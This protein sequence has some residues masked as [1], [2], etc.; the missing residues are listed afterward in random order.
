MAGLESL[1]LKLR[2]IAPGA[3]IEFDLGVRTSTLVA[4]GVPDALERIARHIEANES[5]VEPSRA[6]RIVPVESVHATGLASIVERALGQEGA[7]ESTTLRVRAEPSV[8][9]ISLS[10]APALV[11]FAEEVIRT[12]DVATRGG[13]AEAVYL[14]PVRSGDTE[15]T[16]AELAA[17]VPGASVRSLPM[18]RAIVVRADEASKQGVLRALEDLGVDAAPAVAPLVCEMIDLTHVAP[19]VAAAVIEAVVCDRARWPEELRADAQRSVIQRPPCAQPFLDSASVVVVAPPRLADVATRLALLIDTVQPP[20][21][22][23]ELRAY[24][25][26][27]AAVGRALDAS[28]QALDARAKP[29]IA[30]PATLVDLSAGGLVVALGEPSWLD[31][32]D[33]AVRSVDVR[34]LRDAARVRTMSARHA[35]PRSLARLIEPLLASIDADDAPRATEP[36]VPRERAPT[37][38]A[39]DERGGTVTVIASPM[40]LDLAE[41]ILV[42]LDHESLETPRRSFRLYEL[43]GADAAVVAK[44]IVDRFEL[45]DPGEEPPL[46]RIQPAR[47][48][49]L[50]RASDAQR[51]VIRRLIESM[52]AKAE[53][54]VTVQERM[55]DVQQLAIEPAEVDRIFGAL[56]M[57]RANAAAAAR[58]SPG[59]AAPGATPSQRTAQEVRETAVPVAL[60]VDRDRGLI[61]CFATPAAVARNAESVRQLARLAPSDDATLRRIALPPSANPLE[62]AALA[63]VGCERLVVDD[64][65]LPIG[66][67]VVIAADPAAAGVLLFATERDAAIVRE[68]LA[69]LA[70]VQ[71]TET[72]VARRLVL[73]QAEVD[74]VAGALRFIAAR[75]GGLPRVAV[76]PDRGGVVVMG[77]AAEVAASSSLASRFDRSA[78]EARDELRVL[79]LRS[80]DAVEAASV[81]GLM[82]PANAP[83]PVIQVASPTSVVLHGEASVLDMISAPLMELDKPGGRLPSAVEVLPVARRAAGEVAAEIAAA[84][85]AADE[86]RRERIRIVVSDSANTLFV[87]ADAEL[88]AEVRALLAL[89]D[90]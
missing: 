17:R 30:P 14:H 51:S 69:T 72:V 43:T 62:L 89:L 44:A 5:G 1:V 29:G 54:P 6:L 39:F 8:R 35:S 66:D 86:G 24:P 40:T 61:A 37:R 22:R 18:A 3:S 36:D 10:G 80:I 13:R 59:D 47:N 75:A 70:Q 88:L 38:I 25:L 28:R 19:D 56:A 57:M 41:E 87:R 2:E 76:S 74:R 65:G 27:G 52:L 42:E 20:G 79:P 60:S 81:L 63:I 85:A 49:L 73:A 11:G 32:V 77:R 26:A 9:S 71:R 83:T 50:V 12:L 64:G 23:G 46:V 55:L 16:V 82:C 53:V 45:D 31:A 34:A 67:R 84:L 78:A 68:L 21:R 48:G 15:R 7:D 33:A 90:R 58:Q 4:A